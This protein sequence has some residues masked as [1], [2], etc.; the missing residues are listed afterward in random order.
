MNYNQVNINKLNDIIEPIVVGLN[1][2]LYHIEYIREQN[3]NYLR[4]YIE[5]PNGISLED[6][7]KVSRKISEVIDIKDPIDDSYYLEVSSPGIERVLCTDKH[8]YKYINYNVSINL[9]KPYE[10]SRKYEGKLLSF[11]DSVMTI[12]NDDLNI[13]IPRDKIK[14]V[15]LKGEF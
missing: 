14:K 11:D 2:E 7:E 5:S 1:Y 3:Q 15:I 9:S 8:L 6:C 12:E 4:I 13:S 10:G